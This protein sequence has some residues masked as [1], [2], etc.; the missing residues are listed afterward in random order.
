[1]LSPTDRADVYRQIRVVLVRHLIDIGRLSIQISAG[2]IHLHGSLAR[3]S[4]VETPLSADMVGAIFAELERIKGIKRV[5]GEFD[6]WNQSG[7]AGAW[8]PVKEG[9]R[10][11]GTRPAVSDA[12]PQIIH[13]P[14]RETPP[15]L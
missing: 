9:D 7:F 8:S 3:L 5:D 6:N 2:R 13:I 10:S 11:G 14:V 12:T 1:M 4:G 15:P